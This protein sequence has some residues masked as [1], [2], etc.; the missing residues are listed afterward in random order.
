MIGRMTCA[1]LALIVL[2]LPSATLAQ[3]DEVFR[4]LTPEQLEKFFKDQKVDFKKQQNKAGIVIYDFKRGDF[5]V[6]ML[7]LPG[8]KQLA[9]GG[10]FPPLPLERLNQWNS[11][12][13]FA[14]LSQA[15]G[16]KGPLSVLEYRLDLTG[17]V[18]EGTLK[19]YLARFDEELNAYTKF[20]RGAGTGG[21]TPKIVA[22]KD[23]LLPAVTNEVLEKI[24]KDLKLDYKKQVLPN[25]MALFSFEKNNHRLQ[26]YNFSNKDL[27]IDANF[28]SIPPEDANAYNLKRKFIRV[29]LYKGKQ[30]DYTSLESNLDCAAG[31]TEEMI[32]HFI[33]SYDQDV[34]H[35]RNYVQKIL[36]K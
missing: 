35:F 29:V 6:R 31:V 33:T 17:G 24:L 22:G 18:T 14:A 25:G 23:G 5:N 19:Q 16:P 26:L 8:G 36:N 3:G 7:L 4:A 13:H 34:A 15:K 28:P 12:G 10:I 21:E 9:Y 20:A 30:G 32:R 2:A 1:A 27:M 11:G